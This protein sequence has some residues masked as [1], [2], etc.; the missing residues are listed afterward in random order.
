MI[1]V[2][3]AGHR[4]LGEKETVQFVTQQCSLVLQQIKERYTNVV[5][6]SAI[7]EVADMIFAETAF[8]LNI[9]FEIVRPFNSY[10]EDFQNQVTKNRYLNLQK[11]A[12]KETRLPYSYR[13]EEAY[14]K[15]MQWILHN[16]DLLIAVWDGKERNGKAGTSGAVKE[17]VRT[18][19]TWI[20]LDVI[21]KCTTFHLG[22]NRIIL[23]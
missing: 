16:T 13:S 5:A 3:I 8:S 11:I 1:R 20:H 18:N 2:G 21:Q 14:L 10:I 23:Q 17:A 7:A 19:S 9:P 12:A 4:F 15:A 22:N 6:F